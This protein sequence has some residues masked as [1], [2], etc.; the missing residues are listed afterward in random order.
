MA[1]QIGI[2]QHKKLKGESKTLEINGKQ[3]KE[4]KEEKKVVKKHIL[5][6]MYE[7]IGGK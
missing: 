4:V 3:Y 2:D 5:R 1:L 6:E 7:K